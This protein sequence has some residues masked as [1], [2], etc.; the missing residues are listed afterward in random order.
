[1]EVFGQRQKEKEGKSLYKVL[2]IVGYILSVQWKGD[3][4]CTR[5]MQK[6]RSKFNDYKIGS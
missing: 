5:F 6:L 1:M 4:K 2:G 3:E